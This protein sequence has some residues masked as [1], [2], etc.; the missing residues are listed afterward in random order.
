MA[1]AQMFFLF[2]PVIVLSVFSV[3]SV[4]NLSFAQTKDPTYWQDIRPIFRK[5]CTV[6]HS[7]RYL[8]N[9]DVS[10]GLALDTFEV[11][12]KGERKGAGKEGKKR[13][14]DRMALA[15]DVSSSDFL[16]SG[17]WARLS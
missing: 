14:Q 8:K 17:L 6:C 5:H 7:T 9:P 10:G 16:A 1:F 3:L 2:F 4:V 15:H 11:A 13:C 12:M